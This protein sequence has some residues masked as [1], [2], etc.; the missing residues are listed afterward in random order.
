M[1][2]EVETTAK[3][4]PTLSG[5]VN[6]IQILAGSLGDWFHTFGGL[7]WTNDGNRI[8]NRAISMFANHFSTLTSARSQEHEIEETNGPGNT[9]HPPNWEFREITGNQ[10]VDSFVQRLG[11]S[12]RR[13]S[14]FNNIFATS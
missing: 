11:F 12:I 1:F 5:K 2:A 13:I 9:N 10:A 4:L 7:V 14:L 8:Y 6:G 3:L